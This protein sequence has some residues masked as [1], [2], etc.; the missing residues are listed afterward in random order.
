MMR[1]SLLLV[2]G[3]LAPAFVS[4]ARAEDLVSPGGAV[5][6]TFSIRDLEGAEDCLVYRVS[7]RGKV[8]VA[9]SRL[10]LE[11]EGAPLGEDLVLAGRLERKSDAIWKP[12]YGER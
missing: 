5:A 9:D 6:V 3:A 12:V 1:R 10:G 11:I 4:S 7:F 8:I 2:A